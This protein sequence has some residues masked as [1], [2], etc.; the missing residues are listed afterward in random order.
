MVAG[1]EG[2]EADGRAVCTPLPLA[3][4][5]EA[6]AM[7]DT[8]RQHKP[9]LEVFPLAIGV[10]VSGT[11]DPSGEPEILDA[12]PFRLD[13]WTTLPPVSRFA[14]S[15][16]YDPAGSTTPGSATDPLKVR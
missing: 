7:P 13:T 12:P 5:V 11:L 15:K 10:E 1:T 14:T 6:S 8:R 2:V 16:M 4:N 9:V 3:A